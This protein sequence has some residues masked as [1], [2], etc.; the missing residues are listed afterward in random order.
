MDG[1]KQRKI[2]LVFKGTV[3]KSQSRAEKKK[4]QTTLKMFERG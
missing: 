1:V 2:T 4:L 3:C